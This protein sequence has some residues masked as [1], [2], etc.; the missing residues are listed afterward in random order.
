MELTLLSEAHVRLG[1]PHNQSWFISD[2]DR[3]HA[4]QGGQ[5]ARAD[6]DDVRDYD[7]VGRWASRFVKEDLP[8]AG[9][10]RFRER[11]RCDRAKRRFGR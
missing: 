6:E 3:F 8:A 1:T 4:S 10:R 11:V 7:W 9:E 5:T 2:I